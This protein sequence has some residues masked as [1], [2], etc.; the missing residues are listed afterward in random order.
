MSRVTIQVLERSSLAA[1]IPALAQDRSAEEVL[2]QI[3]A[4]KLPEPDL[5]REN[6]P[7]GPQG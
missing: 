4:I 2:K 1:A 5:S 3:D 6:E 7:P